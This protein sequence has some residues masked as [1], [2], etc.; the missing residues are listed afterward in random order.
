VVGPC[1]ANAVHAVAA[2]NADDIDSL[3]GQNSHSILPTAPAAPHTQ[4]SVP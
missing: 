3:A 4:P 2:G 1:G